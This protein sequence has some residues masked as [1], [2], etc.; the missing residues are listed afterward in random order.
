MVL[1]TL[2]FFVKTPIQYPPTSPELADARGKRI[3]ILIVAYNAA[4]TLGKVFRRMV[5]ER[6]KRSN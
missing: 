4:T 1:L 6:L 2:D 5:V 3:G